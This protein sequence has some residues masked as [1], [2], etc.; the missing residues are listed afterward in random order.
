[1]ETS[2]GIFEKKPQ[3]EIINE[4]KLRYLASKVAI[5]DHFGIPQAHYLALDA[6]KNQKCSANII[7]NYYLYILGMVRTI[8]FFVWILAFFYCLDSGFWVPACFFW[9][10]SENFILCILG[11]PQP[12]G[13]II[14]SG[15][16]A[17]VKDFTKLSMTK[18]V[19]DGRMETTITA[20]LNAIALICCQI[21][22]ILNS[23]PVI[24]W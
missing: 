24:Y 19:F 21:L 20:V 8:H 1:M 22:D 16:S 23:R 6:N 12:L 3:E 9:M 4:Q 13:S 5:C 10:V 15:I 17:A 11:E 2:L 14:D 7:R 18:S